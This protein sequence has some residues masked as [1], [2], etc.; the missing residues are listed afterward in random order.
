MFYKYL[1]FDSKEQLLEIDE[2]K[3]LKEVV[4]NENK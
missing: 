3:W 1:G 2:A 4:D